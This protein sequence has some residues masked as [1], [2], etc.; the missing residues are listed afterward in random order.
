M[1]TTRSLWPYGIIAAVVLFAIGLTAM[2]V[3][4]VRSNSDLVSADYYEQELRFQK[5]LDSSRRTQQLDQRAVVTY[6]VALK[7]INITVPAEHAQQNPVGSVTLYR[8]SSAAMDRSLKLELNVDGS[9]HIDATSLAPGSW[10]VRLLW[11]VGTKEFYM[12]QPIII[13]AAKS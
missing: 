9:Q 6:D 11:T 13:K 4:A 3:M 1:K 12:D 5:Q 8:P 2:I 7:Q 10:K